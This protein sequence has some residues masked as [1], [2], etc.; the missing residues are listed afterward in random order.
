MSVPRC[1]AARRL[2]AGTT[3]HAAAPPFTPLMGYTVLAPGRWCL[4]GLVLQTWC[5]CIRSWYGPASKTLVNLELV[6]ILSSGLVIGSLFGSVLTES[7]GDISERIQKSIEPE[8]YFEFPTTADVF[9]KDPDSRRIPEFAPQQEY[10]I[11]KA[12]FLLSSDSVAV[13]TA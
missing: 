5:S 2:G 8:I 10:R 1:C 6:Q 3:L 12:P 9:S 11:R 4:R 7:I 13:D